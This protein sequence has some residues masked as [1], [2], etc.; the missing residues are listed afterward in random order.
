[1]AS[2]VPSDDSLEKELDNIETSLFEADNSLFEADSSLLGAD[3]LLSR[4]N[5]L[6]DELNSKIEDLEWFRDK[7]KRTPHKISPNGVEL[8]RSG[9]ALY[10]KTSELQPDEFDEH[11][12]E[13]IALI[14]QI[15]NSIIIN[16]A[17]I[18]KCDN[19]VATGTIFPN[20]NIRETDMERIRDK[21]VKANEYNNKYLADCATRIAQQVAKEHIGYHQDGLQ[22]TVDLFKNTYSLT[23]MKGFKKIFTEMA[24]TLKKMNEDMRIAEENL[25]LV[26]EYFGR[27]DVQEKIINE[28]TCSD[29]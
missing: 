6:T 3:K 23:N 5:S 2:W 24:D 21:Y 9:K 8:V 13:I 22:K 28:T 17:E 10:E 11:R 19:L 14:R 29:T 15:S 18:D 27:E 25:D 16:D 4:L 1:M 7:L 20:P 12:K 26:L